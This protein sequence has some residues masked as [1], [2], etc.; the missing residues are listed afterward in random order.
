[1][2]STAHSSELPWRISASECELLKNWL[3]S[4]AP[5][6]VDIVG[7]FAGKERFAI[8]GDA[9]LAH[10]LHTMKVD[11]D[12]GFQILH[13]VHAVETVLCRLRDRGCN[14]HV[15]WFEREYRLSIPE[16]YPAAVTYKYR[17]AREVV[18]QH[19]AHAQKTNGT[20]F[21][22]V[23]TTVH[24]DAFVQYREEHHPHFF[25]GSNGT[26]PWWAG[27]PPRL[28]S[29]FLLYMI[30]SAGYHVACVE[31][32]EFKSSRAFLLIASPRRGAELKGDP[33]CQTTHP[34]PI[35]ANL[36]DRLTGLIATHNLTAREVI[37]LYSLAHVLG[38]NA[39][40]AG[41]PNEVRQQVAA[42]LL[43]IVL[44][45]HCS[46]TNRSFEPEGLGLRPTSAA[47]SFI[48][49]WSGAA[50]EILNS[51]ASGP[52]ARLAWDGFDLFDGRLY[53]TLLRSLRNIHLS[54]AIHKE[55]T[56][57]SGLLKQ[58]CGYDV[59]AQ[60]PV[61][62]TD[63]DK[64]AARLKNL[65]L[66]SNQAISSFSVLPFSH[67]VLDEFLTSVR[68]RTEDANS[69]P[70]GSKVHKELTHWHNNKKSIDPKQPTRA[71]GFFARR[72]NQRF[73]ADIMA[74]SASL[75]GASGK[76][77]EPE[78]I[79]VRSTVEQSKPTSKHAVDKGK[80]QANPDKPQTKSGKQ[81]AL[82]EAELRRA[83]KFQDKLTAIIAFWK[84][85]CLEFSKEPSPVKRYLRAEKCLRGLSPVHLSVVG[86]EVSLFLCHVLRQIQGLYDSTTITHSSVL[87]M[88]WS[89]IQQTVSLIVTEDVHTLV[90]MVFQSF[91]LPLYKLPAPLAKRKL[92]F[93]FPDITSGD[94]LPPGKSSLE[95]QLE[96]CG[97]FLERSF[98]SAP[99]PRVSFE[100]DA[101]QRKV[102]DA[103]DENKSLLVVAPTSAG[104]TFISFYA[105]KKV[106][107]ANNDDV[108]VYVAPTKAL[109][110]Q[111]AAEIQARFSK[112]YDQ[113]ARSVWAIHTRDYRINNVK[114][115]QILVTVPD[116]LQILLLAPSNAAGPSS[117]AKR[118]KRIIFDEVHC[119]GQAEDGII[120]EQ[121][122]LLAPCPIIALSATVANPLEFRDWLRHAQKVKGY[123]LEMVVHS[124]RYSDLRKFIHDP[125]PGTYEFAG[126]DPVER[127]P[128]PGL[129]SDCESPLPFLSLHPI[130]GIIDRSRDTLNDASLEPRDCIELWKHMTKHQTGQYQVPPS[131]NPEKILPSLV[132]KSD[133]TK[134]ESALKDVLAK[135]MLD[136][137]SPF[138]NLRNDLRGERFDRL[139]STYGTLEPTA[140]LTSQSG[141]V[142]SRSS[143]FSLVTDLRS[144]GALPAILFNYDRVGCEMILRELHDTLASAEAAYK[145]HNAQWKK[146]LEAFE[147]WKKYRE[148]AKTKE[149]KAKNTRSRKDD[150][151]DV[152]SKGDRARNEAGQE[153]SAWESFDPEAALQ[154]YSF[155]DNTKV[156]Q[157]EL[158]ARIKSL[159]ADAV[160]PWI[161]NA[162]YRGIGVHHAG[163]NRQY[164]QIVEVFFRKGYLT[165]V[166]ATGTL[167]MGLN[168]PCKTVVFT[169]DSV[170]LTALNYRQ[171]SG[172]AGRRGFDLLGNVVF[173]GLHPHRVLEIMSAKLPDLR[174]QFPTSI[175]LIL[176]LFILLHGTENSEFAANA[177]KGLLTQNRICLGGPDAKMS[178]AHHLRF[179]IDYLRREHLLSEKGVPLNFSG[180]VGH[181]YYTENAVFAF[182]ALLKDGYF[183]DLCFSNRGRQEILLETMLVL[184]HLFCRQACVQHNNKKFLERVHRSPS[185]GILP[186]LPQ[187]AR[188]I[189]ERHNQQTL[190]VFQNYVSS[191]ADQHLTGTP[192][193]RLPFTECEVDTIDDQ[194]MLDLS[195][196]LPLSESPRQP[197]IVRSPFC[198]LSGFTDKFDTIHELCDTVRAGVFLEESAVPY[199]PI[200][201]KETGGVPWNA[202][203]YD[204][205]KHGDMET[206]KSVNQI[207]GGDVWY[208]LK[209]FSLILSSIVTS[210]ANFLELPNAGDEFGIED[211]DNSNMA[212]DGEPQGGGAEWVDM[213]NDPY[214]GPPPSQ[215]EQKNKAK[216]DEV[217]E[218]WDAESSDE[219]TDDDTNAAPKGGSSSY[220]SAFGHPQAPSWAEDGGKS[221]MQIFRVFSALRAE[222]DEKFRKT[223]A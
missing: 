3:Q 185:V 33:L 162:L 48:C 109:V 177:V 146:K 218:S 92:S 191:Y 175:T 165:V 47:N 121:L 173:H 69:S 115:C 46:I 28:G 89:Q 133:V 210:M 12:Y 187:K 140:S 130:A 183:R 151:D 13:A 171:A 150:G 215:K 91:K 88:L 113:E 61:N 50:H 77:I 66:Q 154:E 223:F 34:V 198:A 73:M 22:F 174:G 134:W 172:R 156:A 78:T 127:L 20:P 182:H 119:I 153:L 11:F 97:P 158:N 131:L 62:S 122:L 75:T 29:L 15:L 74:Y 9:L 14:F 24:G 72:R 94:L 102:L 26:T 2:A 39:P 85:R 86:G 170:F 129:D 126:F 110:N 181:L 199:I 147:E 139:A 202:Y 51:W 111:I 220:G 41:K 137:N 32:L 67:P 204:F 100:P 201:P 96:H 118:I 144:H 82:E 189:L 53:L 209:D 148:T 58:L 106:L 17:L 38:Q 35:N 112:R 125:S 195:T 55:V 123:D 135:W 141:Q 43:Q 83:A 101:W 103:I 169:G 212:D 136:P 179:S 18:I 79:V 120:W 54:S 21:S 6:K 217:V 124:S 190:S 107:E 57:L 178:I 149:A 138:E 71:P 157:E 188:E 167:A 87:A 40:G 27:G 4:L 36:G 163:M 203:L 49:S 68:L 152:M 143:V 1:M 222:F 23:F 65:N 145:Q 16:E 207:K 219:K 184:S 197:T 84:Q 142:V 160:R 206:L 98:D 52:F 19:F 196:V 193:N 176:R 128:F 80:K 56:Q 25:L 211:E 117:F 168:M 37:S 180:L 64:E 208:H 205:F 214:A 200:A 114:G 132:K 60:W 42:L 164:R 81:K 194:S 155:A 31:H 161:L 44:M 216:K 186:D 95:F 99:D 10:C 76:I 93:N 45:G 159:G 63:D 90:T 8:H 213:R 166:V 5:T 108:L 7:D 192:D 116:I 221:L 30:S 70:V 59:T 104:K 105:M